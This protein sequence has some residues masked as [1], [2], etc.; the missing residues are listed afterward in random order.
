[1]ICT[2]SV[3]KLPA[4]IGAKIITPLSPP[5]PPH[6]KPLLRWVPYTGILTLC[7]HYTG[8]YLKHKIKNITKWY[9]PLL[10]NWS[11][12]IEKKKNTNIYHWNGEHTKLAKCMHQVNIW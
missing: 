7:S 10:L 8:T 3:E 9:Q 5:P 2:A 11:V 1:M 12:C 6:T 4:K